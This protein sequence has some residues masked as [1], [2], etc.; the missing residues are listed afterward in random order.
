MAVSS[1]LSPKGDFKKMN[2]P[3]FKNSFVRDKSTANEIVKGMLLLTFMMKVV[4][5]A[6][7][8]SLVST[9]VIAIVQSRIASLFSITNITTYVFIPLLLIFMCVVLKVRNTPKSGQGEESFVITDDEMI[10][11]SGIS[12]QTYAI[13]N[14]AMYYDT[15]DYI[16]IIPKGRNHMF[17]AIKKDSFTLGNAEDFIEF[18]K[19]KGI[20]VQK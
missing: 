1:L 7:A 5:V 18:L 16:I 9:L 10:W 15:K 20:K 2:E 3:L 13:N 19:S 11:T 17:P 14:I 8:I 6:F 4:Y 12:T